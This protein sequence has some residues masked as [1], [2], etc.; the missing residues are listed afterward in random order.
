MFD[1]SSTMIPKTLESPVQSVVSS[2]APTE[3]S[4][5]DDDSRL[6]TARSDLEKVQNHL[7]F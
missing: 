5:S 6:S 7:L 1:P 3:V 2:Y 4:E